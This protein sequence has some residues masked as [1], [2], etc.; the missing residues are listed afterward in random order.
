M[1]PDIFSI[2]IL[3]ARPAAGKSEIIDYLK[4]TPLEERQQR[5]HVGELAIIDDF[6]MIW[7][8]FEEDA[9][10][11]KMGHPSLHTDEQ[12]YF[13]WPYLWHV[14]IERIGLDYH[15][16]RRDVA[17][18]HTTILEFSRGSEHGGYREAYQHLDKEILQQAA[19]LYVKVSFEESLRKN[20][21]R[22][23]PDRPDSILEHALDDKKLERLYRE[24]DWEAL[25]A[26]HPEYITSQGIQIPYAVFDNEDDVTTPRG[27]ALGLRLEATL[28]S[29]WEH[30][31]K[32]TLP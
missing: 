23:N 32:Q 20:R 14:L 15:K 29:L 18:T 28:G 21:A 10:L 6:P 2:L 19:I 25:S 24:D 13:K 1:T 11:T 7:S 17:G 4:R 16:H 9:L 3:N 31:F 30:A 12:G 5:F 22:F 27:E 8:W 26:V